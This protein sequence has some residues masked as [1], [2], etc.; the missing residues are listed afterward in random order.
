MRKKLRLLLFF[1]SMLLMIACSNQTQTE[2][3]KKEQEVKVADTEEE[4]ETESVKIPKAPTTVET[5]IKQS[6]GILVK[7]HLDKELEVGHGWNVGDYGKFYDSEFK[8]IIEK[9]LLTYFEEHQ[10]LTKDEVY[11]YL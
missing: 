7:E 5:M 11:D 2:E 9:E 10:E 8:A 3:P 6:E 1:S 4:K